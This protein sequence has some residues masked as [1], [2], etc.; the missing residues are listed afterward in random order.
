MGF[1]GDMLAE[2]ENAKGEI[3]G[4]RSAL[5]APLPYLVRSATVQWGERCGVKGGPEESGGGGGGGG[6]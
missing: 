5:M 6:G 2:D 3:T 1:T 4:A